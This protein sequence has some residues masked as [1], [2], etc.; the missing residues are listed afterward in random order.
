MP[1]RPPARR[2]RPRGFTIIEL[3]VVIGIIGVLLGLLLPALSG[4][5]RRSAKTQELSHLRQV[6]IAWFGYANAYDDSILPGFIETDAQAKWKLRYKYPDGEM[7]PPAP[8]WSSGDPNIAGPWTWRLL[9]YLDNSHAIVHGYLN[10]AEDDMASMI[11]EAQ[12]VAETPAF[13]YNS[14]YMG[15]WMELV[16]VGGSPFVTNRYYNARDP[17]TGGQLN[18]TARSQAHLRR[19][20]ELIVFCSAARVSRRSFQKPPDDIPGFHTVVPPILADTQMWSNDTTADPT[21]IQG[22]ELF[23]GTDPPIPIGRYNGLV[24]VLRADGSCDTQTP[25]ALTDQREWCIEA[26]TSD[27]RHTR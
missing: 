2:P 14:F 19:S 4:V 20:S 3:L 22:L 24:P 7:I 15:G 16:N 12:A 8:T 9:S 21:R 26:D 23:E 10:E 27:F 6:S 11:D 17:S 18:V 5:K 13:A 25:G 1:I